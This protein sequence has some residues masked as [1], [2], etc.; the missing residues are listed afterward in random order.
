MTFIVKGKARAVNMAPAFQ[1]TTSLPEVV[2][3]IKLMTDHEGSQKQYM[4]IGQSLA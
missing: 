2:E 1:G 4:A 3:H